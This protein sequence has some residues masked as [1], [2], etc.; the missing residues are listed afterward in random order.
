M[1]KVIA[2]SL[3]IVLCL[4]GCASQDELDAAYERGYEA[5]Y[6]EGYKAADNVAEE[7]M[8]SFARYLEEAENYLSEISTDSLIGAGIDPRDIM[9][10][11]RARWNIGSAL[12]IIKNI[13]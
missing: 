9:S 4:S 2:L 11:I 5:G 13:G 7:E 1:K 3:I 8:E 6:D 12:D 10:I